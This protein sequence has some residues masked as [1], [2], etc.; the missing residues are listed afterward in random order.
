MACKTGRRE[1]IDGARA[2]YQRQRELDRVEPERLF[3]KSLVGRVNDE[4]GGF[5]TLSEAEQKYFAV[6]MLISEVY[7]GGFDQFFHNH[8]GEY[9]A[10]ASGM[11]LELAAQHSLR[12]LREAKTILFGTSDVPVDTGVRRQFLTT[13][14]VVNADSIQLLDKAFCSDPDSLDQKLA[15]FAVAHGLYTVAT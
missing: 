9:Y 15:S 12:L 1:A 5:H 4:K 2:F 3:W 7:N 14:P 6:Q 8:S 13:H 11:L 10:L